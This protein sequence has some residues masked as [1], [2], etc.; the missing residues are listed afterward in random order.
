MS[1]LDDG[2]KS[3]TAAFVRNII[4]PHEVWCEPYFEKGEVFFKKKASKKEIINDQDNNVVNF[5]LMIRNRWEQLYFLMESTLHCDFFVQLAENVLKNGSQ[6]E[7]HQAWAFWLVCNKAFVSP[8]KWALNDVLSPQVPLQ[9]DI[10]KRII[11][12][13]S[14]R[15][16]NVYISCREPIEVIREANGTETVF[17]L[18]PKTKKE[19]KEV[20]AIWP[21]IK[22][23]IILQTPEESMIKKIMPKLN[24]YTDPDCLPL[25]IYTNFKR[26]HTLFE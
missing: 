12:C 15:L 20:L 6:D 7:L 24:V 9:S 26:I 23:K 18:C 21:E 22:G 2:H 19:L 11:K 25:G 1:P 8:E 17:Y 4:P 16:A 13:L 10:Q 3:A 5:Y 14:E